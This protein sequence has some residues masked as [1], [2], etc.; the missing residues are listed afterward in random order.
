M[1]SFLCLEN[2]SK[3][4]VQN[5]THLCEL[6]IRGRL[7]RHARMPK[8]KF[9]LPSEI[10]NIVDLVY[11]DEN[12]YVPNCFVCKHC[13][14]LM[15]VPKAGGN[16]KLRTHP[17]VKKYLDADADHTDEIYLNQHFLTRDQREVLKDMFTALTG[18]AKI[19]GMLPIDWNAQSWYGFLTKLQS[20]Q[21]ANPNST[22]EIRK[23]NPPANRK[24]QDNSEHDN[25]EKEPGPSND[26]ESDLDGD[27]GL[28]P[29][30]NAN[31]GSL[32]GVESE[33]EY[34]GKDDSDA[35]ASSDE[36]SHLVEDD[37]D[38][39]PLDRVE[40]ENAHSGDDNSD[41][42][43]S[44]DEASQ[45]DAAQKG[46]LMHPAGSSIRSPGWPMQ[47]SSKKNTASNVRSSYKRGLSVHPT[48]INF[49]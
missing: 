21:A 4:K 46:M 2:A 48:K 30:E 45:Y 16:S 33:N 18:Q 44:G 43:A 1:T 27:D 24:I 34:S 8:D 11:D 31:A 10:Y 25:N 35:N 29:L 39:S 6:I 19:K 13:S 15:Y 47:K 17:C 23:T 42:N 5:V 22:A 49:K 20:K 3:I 12:R 41:A 26:D 37:S 32:D 28:D 14:Y 38:T 36:A 7:R 40:S 9:K